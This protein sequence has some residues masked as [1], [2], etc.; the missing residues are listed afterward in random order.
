MTTYKLVD[1]KGKVTYFTSFSVAYEY[2]LESENTE[3]EIV[4]FENI[5]EEDRIKRL[6][7]K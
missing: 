5:I 3:N 1:K 2:M 6:D 4:L 7:S